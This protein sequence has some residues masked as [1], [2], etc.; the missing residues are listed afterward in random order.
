M[1][2]LVREHL[3]DGESVPAGERLLDELEP[4][5]TCAVNFATLLLP[6]EQRTT[7]RKEFNTEAWRELDEQM[8]KGVR[9]LGERLDD[10]WTLRGL[11]SLVYGVPKLLAGLDED[12]PPSPELKK[13]QRIFFVALYQ[14][15]CSSDTGLVCLPC[16]CRSGENRRI[17][18]CLC[19]RPGEII[20]LS[21]SSVKCSK[22]GDFI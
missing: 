19:Q 17:V 1:D 10:S 3:E 13:S 12:A 21:Y 22:L 8:Q 14:L 20:S 9:M 11:T 5:L 6:P 4:R 2:R 18:S 15:L 7:I 16:F